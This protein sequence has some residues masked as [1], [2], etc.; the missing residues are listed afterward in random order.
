MARYEDLRRAALDVAR[1]SGDAWG[2]AVFLR[3]G[4]AAW[5]RAW[6]L[7]EEPLGTVQ[8]TESERQSLPSNQQ[9][10]AILA[11]MVLTAGQE[12]LA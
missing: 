1:P 5:M 3:Q 12:V 9:L 10:I 11:N 8:A 6:P 2:L 4:M 7:P